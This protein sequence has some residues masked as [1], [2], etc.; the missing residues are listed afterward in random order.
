MVLRRMCFS[1][2]QTL[3]QDFVFFITPKGL[4][5]EFLPQT[6]IVYGLMKYLEDLPSYENTAKGITTLK[7]FKLDILLQEKSILQDPNAPEKL[8]QAWLSGNVQKIAKESAEIF[9]KNSKSR[10]KDSK[11]YRKAYGLLRGKS[12]GRYGS[13]LYGNHPCQRPH[14]RLSL[15]AARYE[16]RLSDR[17]NEGAF[18]AHT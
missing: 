16:P 13:Y 10:I 6:E 15:Q 4:P 3:L 18:R 9:S 12:K 7:N 14:R 11:A 2:Y 1:V 5:K 8:I 17:K